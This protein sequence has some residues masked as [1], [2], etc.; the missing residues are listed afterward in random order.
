MDYKQTCAA[1]QEIK[2]VLTLFINAKSQ[3]SNAECIVGLKEYLTAK[4]TVAQIVF[5]PEILLRPYTLY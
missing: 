5:N 4:T 3:L 2:A 1:S